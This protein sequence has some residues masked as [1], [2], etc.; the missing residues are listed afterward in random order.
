MHLVSSGDKFATFMG[1]LSDVEAGGGTSFIYPDKEM[2]LKPMKGSVVFWLNLSASHK[3]DHRLNH[4][5]CPVISSQK[6][7]VNKWIYG[8]DQWKKW[9]CTL[10]I[11]DFHEPA[12][13]W[14][15]L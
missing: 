3:K 10:N 8:F 6:W 13:S 11:G 14:M 5:G 7:I 12:N 1:W 9:P 15:Q 2:S 4:G